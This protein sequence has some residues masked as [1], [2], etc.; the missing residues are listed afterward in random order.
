MKRLNEEE[1]EF[2]L[3]RLKM[4]EEEDADRAKRRHISELEA[5]AEADKLM[6]LKEAERHAENYVFNNANRHVP[7]TTQYIRDESPDFPLSQVGY[8]DTDQSESQIFETDEDLLGI[9]TDELEDQCNELFSDTPIPFVRSKEKKNELI[10][11]LI[12]SCISM[13]NIT[14]PIMH[15][16]QKLYIIGSQRI[17]LDVKNDQLLCRVGGGYEKFHEYVPKNSKYFQKMLVVH[18]IK[19]GESLEWVIDQLINGKKIKN[20]HAPEPSKQT[21]S[22]LYQRRSSSNMKSQNSLK[23][24]N[25]GMSGNMRKSVGKSPRV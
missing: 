18:M 7:P 3:R 19:S 25:S 4:I 21:D 12:Q 15:I 20:I 2:L 10:D 1:A 17:N 8:A 13:Y 14:I 24:S 11:N 23:R 5:Q 9:T 6:R 22:G 16:K